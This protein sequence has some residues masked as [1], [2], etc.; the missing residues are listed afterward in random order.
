[1]RELAV[2]ELQ[3]A[4]AGCPLDLEVSSTTFSGLCQAVIA[5]YDAA[6]NRAIAAE[7]NCFELRSDECCVNNGRAGILPQL[8]QVMQDAQ[9]RT[10]PGLRG[11]PHQLQC[12]LGKWID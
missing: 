6:L 2:P 12:F 11:I 8:Q 7:R 1:M 3:V 10:W 4:A 5:K 9:K